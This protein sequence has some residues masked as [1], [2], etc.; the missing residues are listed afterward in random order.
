ML[1]IKQHTPGMIEVTFTLI[2]C[3]P[4]DM[5]FT[6]NLSITFMPAGTI[7]TN[8]TLHVVASDEAAPTT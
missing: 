4:P 2:G 8:Q 7:E 5:E 3:P 6:T 1:L